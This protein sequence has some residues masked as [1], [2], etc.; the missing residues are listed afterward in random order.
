MFV[1]I[2]VMF[3]NNQTLKKHRSWFSWAD[4]TLLEMNKSL[5]VSIHT[6]IVKT[7]VR[8]EADEYLQIFFEVFSTIEITSNLQQ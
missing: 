6:Y 7:C 8:I 5:S 1:K 3:W 2:D 4:T